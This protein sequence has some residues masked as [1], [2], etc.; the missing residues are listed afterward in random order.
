MTRTL[1]V[2][3][4]GVLA[5]VCLLA[6][7]SCVQLP[8][9]GPV[10]RGDSDVASD[11]RLPS[12]IDPQHPQPGASR[13]D[14]VSGFLDAM[15][16]WPI[17]TTVAK[18][19]LT[20]D[21]SR[22]WNPEAST[23][24]YASFAPPTDG[25]HGVTVRLSGAS[26]LDSSGAWRGA[27]RAPQQTL[28]FHVVR[29]HGDFRIANPPDAL[30][31]P[32]TWFQQR[33]GQVA[34]YYFEPQ[35]HHLVPEPV[36]VPLGDQ[37]PSALMTALLTG[38][39]Q[40]LDGVVRTFLPAGLSVGLSV[41]VTDGVADIGLVGEQAQPSGQEVRL[42][43]AQV[44]AT[45][46]QDPEVTGFRITL[47]GR[48][49]RPGADRTYPV[50][51]G[52]RF[53]P[54]AAGPNQLYAVEGTRMVGGDASGML[55]APGPFGTGEYGL[56]EVAVA[57]DG[58]SAVA[59]TGHGTAATQAP[60]SSAPDPVVR[61]L[62]GGT[63]LARPT[64]DSSGRVW[65]VDRRRHGAVVW[66]A[67]RGR[68]TSVRVPGVTG[69]DV[70]RL[71]VSRDGTRLLAVVRHR[72]RDAVV[73]VRVNTWPDGRVRRTSHPF[74]IPTGRGRVDDVA[75]ASPTRVAILTP[76]RPGS[77]YQVDIV[78]ADGSTVGAVTLSTVLGGH[79]LGLAGTPDPGQ[80]TYAVL[81]GSLV[82]VRTRLSVPLADRPLSLGYAG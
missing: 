12:D 26:R 52:D 62:V 54:T 20:D 61:T 19:Y 72:T 30:V 80:P 70:R 78:P 34:L 65:L 28:E 13:L 56:G 8:E 74:V 11:T 41:P 64:I 79:V 81:R 9:S 22:A 57:P 55:A 5:L 82:D 21:A 50:D 25:P 7:A 33:F 39:P 75:W 29:Q 60:L 16:A 4:R 46:H 38:P 1:R 42:L 40:G 49:V 59:I 36:F 6:C 45:L 17:S 15:T 66:C 44:A 76:T 67:D 51:L 47:N 37:L 69:N 71:L 23:V 31:V 27:V 53:T 24:M 18:E 73:G 35:A 77:L 68:T 14:V 63:D 3:A 48:P 32:T 2:R 43:L 58:A 10:S